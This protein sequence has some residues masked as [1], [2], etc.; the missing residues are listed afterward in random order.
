MDVSKFRIPEHW[1]TDSKAFAR[2]AV[3][4]IQELKAALKQ[5]LLDIIG[6]KDSLGKAQTEIRDLRDKLGTNST[7]SSLPPSKDPPSAPFQ[8]TTPTGRKQGA[9]KGHPGSGRKLF[10]PERVDQSMDVF[11]KWCPVSQRALLPEEMTSLSLKRVHQID[12]PEEIRLVVTEVRL[13]TCLCPCGCGKILSGVMPADL[14]NTAVG[15]RLKAMMALIT[16]RF[17]LS[18]SLIREF[19]LDLFGPDATF[20]T[21]CISEAEEEIADA[22]EKPYVEAREAVQHAPAVH[23]DETSWFLKHKLHWLWIA[24]TQALSVFYIDP[25]RSRAAF[26]RFL[27]AFEGFIISDRFSAYANLSPEERQLCWA[28]LIRDFRKLVDRH[29]GAEGIGRWALGEIETM[30]ALWHMYLDGEIDLAKLRQEFVTIR[31]RFGRLLKLGQ[32]TTDKKAA[33]FCKKL[34]NMWPALWNFLQR[35]DILQPTNNPAEQGVRPAVI[36]RLL[37]L[38]SQSDRGLRFTERMLTVVTSLRRQGRR[39]LDFLQEALLAFRQGGFPP[40]L[41]VEPSG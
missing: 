39:I 24:V 32:E 31:A 30:F 36:G 8:E 28:H 17:H 26:E 9:Q 37:S 41:L 6:L 33:G 22:L 2:E 14:G 18:K 7:N 4:E 5:A 25:H 12:L 11:P 3:S 35:P 1:P 23:V 27:G 21:G 10:P 15:P 38:G 34:T 13:H 20:S 40:S 19:L 16:S 29:G